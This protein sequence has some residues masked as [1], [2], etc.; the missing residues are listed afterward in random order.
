MQYIVTYA[1]G[2]Y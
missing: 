2:M 1:F